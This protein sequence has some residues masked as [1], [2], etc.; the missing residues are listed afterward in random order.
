MSNLNYLMKLILISSGKVNERY[1][2]KKY[3]KCRDKLNGIVLHKKNEK[4]S[5]RIVSSPVSFIFFFSDAKTLINKNLAGLLCVSEL[6]LHL[7][8]NKGTFGARIFVNYFSRNSPHV[9][10]GKRRAAH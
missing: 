3:G 7:E 10:S 9:Y 6:N 5:T 1:K 4:I 8:F 2:N